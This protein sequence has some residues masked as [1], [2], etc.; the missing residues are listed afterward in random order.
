MTYALVLGYDC[1]H[2]KLDAQTKQQ[3]LSTIKTRLAHIDADVIGERSRVA[4]HPRD[5]HAQLSATML[6]MMATLMA[7][8]RR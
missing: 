5:S 8:A 7:D 1:L 6:G 4:R 2:P 3:L